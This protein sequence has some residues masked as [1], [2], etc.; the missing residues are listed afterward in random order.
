M[1]E[2]E[3]IN[4]RSESVK[5][6]LERIPSI[7]L[8]L[9]S[10]IILLIIVVVVVLSL[11]IRYP[12]IVKSELRL[13]NEVVLKPV[14][15]KSE[16]R[17]EKLFVR[18]HEVVTKGEMLGW[19]ESSAKHQ[20]VLTLESKL[21]SLSELEKSENFDELGQRN[22]GEYRSL[23]EIQGMFQD[24]QKS[25]AR[26]IMAFKDGMYQ[27]KY[28][29]LTDELLE[30]QKQQSILK[31]QTILYQRD[32]EL[33]NGELLLNKRL[34]NEKVISSLDLDKEESKAIAKRIP[35]K[36]LELNSVE[37]RSKILEKEKE[38]LELNAEL[39]EIKENFSQSL[40]SL[41]SA[42]FSWKSKYLL[43]APE[44]G[45]VYFS[46]VIQENQH[47]KINS[48]VFYVGKDSNSFF[49]ETYIPQINFGKVKVG[50]RVLIKFKG[51]P[52]EEYG[53]VEG[54]IAQIA[55][56]PKHDQ[57]SFYASVFVKS[58]VTSKG[59]SLL[60]KNGMSASAEIVTEDISLAK[61]IFYDISRIISK[62]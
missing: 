52:Y 5:D 29:I 42:I 22:I 44:D 32:Y 9:G 37:N 7:F 10:Y 27:A 54:K 17:L 13:A 3:D 21:I 41:F 1:E 47:L 8:R 24:F 2:S 61:R 20:D 43:I 18:E 14:V 16:G 31:E 26:I 12:T 35:L 56:L 49:G 57:D 51:Y 62:R 40:S 15:A 6:Y 55:S 30:L 59:D 60:Y 11:I 46:N 45:T 50:Q 4:L 19:I 58:N 48:E 28:R 39:F 53:L 38:M 23:G 34:F 33:A 25:H 36:N